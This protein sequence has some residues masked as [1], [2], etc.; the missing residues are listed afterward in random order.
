MY[1]CQGKEGCELAERGSQITKRGQWT[2]SRHAA[3]FFMITAWELEISHGVQEAV[4]ECAD[5]T[6]QQCNKIHQHHEPI[7]T[8]FKAI[9]SDL[10]VSITWTELL[11]LVERQMQ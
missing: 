5:S 8:A 6:Q 9:H 3:F 4:H 1:V 11:L 7:H 2:E 10:F